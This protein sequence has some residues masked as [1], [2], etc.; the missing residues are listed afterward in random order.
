MIRDETTGYRI[1]YNR[2]ADDWLI[3]ISGPKS[4]AEEIKTKVKDFLF[5][6]LQLVLNEDKTRIAHITTTRV[7][8]LGYQIGRRSRKYTESLL[9]FVKSTGRTR[10]AANT[11]I[12]IYV[13]KQDLVNKTIE[14]GFAW[15]KTKPRAVTKWIYLTPWEI[16]SKYNAI[17]RGIL[18]YYQMVENKNLLTHFIWI[19]KFSL[20]FTLARK[21]NCSP[22]KVWKKLGKHITLTV[23][24]KSDNKK[25]TIK[26]Y[27]P[28]SL[29]R[30]RTML[31]D[32]YENRDPFV[33]KYYQVRSHHVWDSSCIICSSEENIEMHHVRH[34]KVK[35]FTQVMKQLNRK[36]I[37]VC[38]RCH[39]KIHNGEYDGESLRKIKMS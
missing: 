28:K 11:R 8:Y 23:H 3:G 32:G 4:F 9:S 13:P 30:N 10:R 25:K 33:V 12:Q 20:V 21:W 15:D 7:N 36:Q 34:I 6:Q 2:Y 5:N 24:F 19:M 22:A 26:F 29:A 17:V 31:T 16:I 35:G 39:V 18:N 1:Y 37:P 27:Q 38:K 14:N